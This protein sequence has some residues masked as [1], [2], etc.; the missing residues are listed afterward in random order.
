MKRIIGIITFLALSTTIGV[1]GETEIGQFPQFWTAKE[2]KPLRLFASKDLILDL[3][4]VAETPQRKP[5]PLRALC[6]LAYHPRAFHEKRLLWV[7]VTMSG[8]DPDVLSNLRVCWRDRTRLAIAYQEGAEGGR[9]TFAELD[10]ESKPKTLHTAFDREANELDLFD[11]L[12]KGDPTVDR[13]MVPPP[14]NVIN[15]QRISGGHRP[16]IGYFQLLPPLDVAF[17]MHVVGVGLRSFEWTE[18]GWLAEL[19][20]HANGEPTRRRCDL[21]LFQEKELWF[22]KVDRIHR[23]EKA[24]PFERGR[25]KQ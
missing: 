5:Y 7:K 8:Q 1:G 19:S 11:R 9:L 4:M 24:T 20:V 6:V 16:S 2:G 3:Q 15:T 13:S 23:P 25:P 14:D 12:E 10:C 17:P 21:L 18:R 22:A